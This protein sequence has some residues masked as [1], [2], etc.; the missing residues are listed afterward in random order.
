[1]IAD[2]R[3]S[4]V[5]FYEN[6]TDRA[7]FRKH[8]V[9]MLEKAQRELNGFDEGIAWRLI[10]EKFGWN[11]WD[12]SD[13]VPYNKATYRCFVGTTAELKKAYPDA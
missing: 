2:N 4:I 1:M 12:V 11:W 3:N 5:S 9:E 8:L 13:H 7:N 6:S 10:L